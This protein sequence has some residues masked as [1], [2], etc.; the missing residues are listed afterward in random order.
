MVDAADE[1]CKDPAKSGALFS[2]KQIVVTTK[3]SRARS[4]VV[5]DFNGGGWLDLASASEND[6]TIAWYN[7][8][9][10]KGTFGQQIVVTTDAYGVESVAVGDLNVHFKIKKL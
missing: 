9:D 7:N 8:T 10:G 1:T 5:G 6:N 4:V 3:A 2:N